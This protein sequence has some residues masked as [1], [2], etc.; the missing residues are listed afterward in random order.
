MRTLINEVANKVYSA[1]YLAASPTVL[2]DFGDLICSARAH[3]FVAGVAYAC[4]ATPADAVLVADRMQSYAQLSRA[5]VN[6]IREGALQGK[7][8]DVAVSMLMGVGK[9]L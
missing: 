6:T 2:R 4:G 1:D 3:R 5:Q 7:A 9:T 8:A